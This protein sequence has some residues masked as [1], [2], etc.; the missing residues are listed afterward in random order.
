MKRFLT[1]FEKGSG[2]FSVKRDEELNRIQ[3]GPSPCA[4]NGIGWVF[5]LR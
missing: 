2:T 1:L 4:G 3:F 5:S